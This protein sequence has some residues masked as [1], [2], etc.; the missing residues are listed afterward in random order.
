MRW[1]NISLNSNK[2]KVLL[3]AL[4]LAAIA[5]SWLVLQLSAQDAAKTDE[6]RSDAFM[7]NVHAIHFNEL[8]KVEAEFFSPQML[9]YPISNITIMD[10]PCFLIHI[11]GKPPW[12]ITAN[13][14]KAY[15]GI[16]RLALW[17]T[18]V[19]YQPQSAI[20]PASTIQTEQIMVFPSQK[21]AETNREVIA[22][23]SGLTLHSTGAT[24]DLNKHS[25]KLLKQV[26]GEYVPTP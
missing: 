17:D 1:L 26:R 14:G 6:H 25:I 5:S 13:K 23:Q 18:V 15:E 2:Q 21:Y 24:V 9:H 4:T 19:G 12:Q 7:Q 8:G 10:K 22:K 11:E 20:N 3:I 16:K